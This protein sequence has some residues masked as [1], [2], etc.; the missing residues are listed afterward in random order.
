MLKLQ[1]VLNL[2]LL[3]CGA[4]ALSV[5]SN[6][7][8]ARMLPSDGQVT[9]NPKLNQQAFGTGCLVFADATLTLNGITRNLTRVSEQGNTAITY[10]VNEGWPPPGSTTNAIAYAKSG[11]TSGQ[12][13]T[14][15][16]KW[17]GRI[18]QLYAQGR[19]NNLNWIVFQGVANKM[20]IAST[21][22]F[23]NVLLPL[24]RVGNVEACKT[25]FRNNKIPLIVAQA[26]YYVDNF[27]V[28]HS[29]LHPGN[30]LWDNQAT[31]PTLIDWGTAKDTPSWT[32]AVATQVTNQVEF[33]HLTGSEAI[34]VDLSEPAP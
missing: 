13:F 32:T 33:S 31:S 23:A 19:F 29:D 15:E 11:R 4:A 17:L 6:E 22:Y 27:Q 3:V 1:T 21:A 20:H 5:S 2:A 10:S 26:K 9:F 30:V 24:L 12:T 28:L 7:R 16:I 25:Q 34:C 18:N 14:D 8:M